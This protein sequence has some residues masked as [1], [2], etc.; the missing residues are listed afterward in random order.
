MQILPIHEQISQMKSARGNAFFSSS[1]RDV[2]LATVV[3]SSMPSFLVYSTAAVARLWAW[4]AIYRTS[5]ER[6][7]RRRKGLVVQRKVVAMIERIYLICGDMPCVQRIERTSLSLGTASRLHHVPFEVPAES[8]DSAYSASDSLVSAWMWQSGVASPASRPFIQL[9]TQRFGGP[10]RFVRLDTSHTC[11]SL[12]NKRC[13][14]ASER[15]EG[16]VGKREGSAMHLTHL[17]VTTTSHS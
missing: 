13:H 1:G 6:N 11:C 17:L 16:E 9:I 7:R 2:L 8:E 15:K 3:D 14:N 5:R 12:K 10:V 4:S